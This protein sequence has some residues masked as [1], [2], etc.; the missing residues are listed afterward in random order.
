MG[1]PICPK[2][3][4]NAHTPISHAHICYGRLT[5]YFGVSVELPTFWDNQ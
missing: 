2:A 4:G 3:V 5:T 1:A